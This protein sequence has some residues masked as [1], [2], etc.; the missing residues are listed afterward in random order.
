MPVS[1]PSINRNLE[2]F[3][4]HVDEASSLVPPLELISY[5]HRPISCHGCV[6]AILGP[7]QK[8][9]IGRHGPVVTVRRRVDILAFH[10]SSWFGVVETLSYDIPEISEAAEQ[11]AGMYIVEMR[12]R[13][14]PVLVR[15]VVDKEMDVLWHGE[16]LDG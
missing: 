9:P 4:L 6:V 2:D 5:P 7:F 16:G 3:F 12:W 13:Q 10:I 14:G 1:R 8:R 15:G 11:H